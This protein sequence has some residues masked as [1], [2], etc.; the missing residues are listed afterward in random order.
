MQATTQ[1][2]RPRWLPLLMALLVAVMMV[3]WDRTAQAAPSRL[4]P[5]TAFG[6]NPGNLLMFQIVPDDLPPRAPLVVVMHGCFVTAAN[7]DDE[8][9]WAELADRWNVALVFPQQ[10]QANQPTNCFSWW[11]PEDNTRGKGE[12]LSVKQMVDW[13]HTNHGTDAERTYIAGHSGGGL[14]TAV[15]LA[16]YPDVFQAGAILSAGAYKCGDEG[17]VAV[18]V[19]GSKPPLRGGECVDGSTD[20]TPQQ[21]GD[22]A[23][24]GFPGYT[25]PKPRVSI[26]HGTA[27][28]LMSPKNLTELVEQWTNYHDA[29]LT[30]EISDTIEG[31]PH[32]VYANGEGRP[33]VESYS[34][35]G[36]SHGWSYDPGTAAE[37][38]N[39]SLPSSSDGICTTYYIG[40]WFGLDRSADVADRDN[41]G[42]GDAADNCDELANVDQRDTDRD[43]LGDACDPETTVDID[44][45]PG[46]DSTT[47]LRADSSG[48]LPVA[49]LSSADFDAIARTDQLS[50]RFGKTGAEQSLS[51]HQGRPQCETGDVNGDGLTDVVCHFHKDELGFTGDEGDTT[52]VLMGRTFDSKPIVIRGEDAMHVRS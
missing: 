14:F 20:K 18:G 34:L 46:E 26:W 28:P 10:N 22:L 38:C 13:M 44:V 30:P 1:L 24:S 12:A 25:G 16:T 8:T 51:T 17:A 49:I 9:G 50:L 41:D 33:V 52:A 48:K 23:R 5:V 7:F 19:D 3:V 47:R 37:Q 27:D 31:Y 32:H 40:R 43:G 42:I 39:G 6:S 2:A 4:T 11:Q 35:T 21:W 36:K 45:Q 29:D 15:M